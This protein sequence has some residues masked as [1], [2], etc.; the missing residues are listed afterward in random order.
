MTV[1]YLHEIDTACYLHG[2]DTASYLHD[3]DVFY[4]YVMLILS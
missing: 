1:F 3:I 4:L 2:I